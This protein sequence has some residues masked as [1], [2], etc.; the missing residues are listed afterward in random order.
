MDVL[1]GIEKYRKSDLALTQNTKQMQFSMMLDEDI[2]K[3]NS[4][5]Y[6]NVLCLSKNATI[7]DQQFTK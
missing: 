4:F 1:Q 3:V 6:S 5:L 7:V 2:S